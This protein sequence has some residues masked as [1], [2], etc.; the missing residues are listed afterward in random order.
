[1]SEKF[2]RKREKVKKKRKKK[3]EGLNMQSYGLKRGSRR[4]SKK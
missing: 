4:E 1:M 3:K 2:N